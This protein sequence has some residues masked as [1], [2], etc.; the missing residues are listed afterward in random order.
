MVRGISNRFGYRKNISNLF[1]YY[2]KYCFS[3]TVGPSQ[4]TA[5][6]KFSEKWRTAFLRDEIVAVSKTFH[7]LDFTRSCT[8]TVFLWYNKDTKK[9]KTLLFDIKNILSFDKRFFNF[10]D[11]KKEIIYTMFNINERMISYEIQY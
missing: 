5:Q 6:K 9:E 10:I 11:K 7:W 8:C 4:D 1:G 2:R 3:P